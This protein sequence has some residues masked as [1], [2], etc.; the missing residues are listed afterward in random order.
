MEG[1]ENPR[2][3]DLLHGARLGKGT[4]DEAAFPQKDTV[5]FTFKTQS[6]W[7]VLANYTKTTIRRTTGGG[8]G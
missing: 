1:N 5:G 4:F 3:A 6:V 8:M 2:S 7:L